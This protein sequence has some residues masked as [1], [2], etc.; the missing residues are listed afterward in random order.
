MAKVTTLGITSIKM[1]A[2]AV[3][4]GV[5][6]SLTVIGSTREDTAEMVQEDP[7]KTELFTEESDTPFYTA[8]KQGKI[9]FNFSLAE[10]DVDQLARVFGGTTSGT[11]KVWDM[12]TAVVQLEQTL[13]IN[14]KVGMKFLIPRGLV[15]AKMGG[16]FSKNDAFAVAI[17]VDVLTPTKDGVPPLRVTNPA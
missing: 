9:S 15:T 16:K 5:G 10:P 12:P 7:T 2:I 3:D 13:E 4:G 11:P 6:T 8:V 17:T 14:P 1:G